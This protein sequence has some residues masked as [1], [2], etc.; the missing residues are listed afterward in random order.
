VKHN[1]NNSLC[2]L[3]MYAGAE[4][5]KCSCDVDDPEDAP[6][7]ST[8]F[9]PSTRRHATVGPAGTAEAAAYAELKAAAIDLDA[10]RKMLEPCEKRWRAALDR[11]HEEMLR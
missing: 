6:G 3:V 2:D 1:P 7:P 9:S 8:V 4:D 11:L 5:V 10:A